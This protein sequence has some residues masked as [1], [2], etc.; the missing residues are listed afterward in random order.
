LPRAHGEPLACGVLRCAPEDFIV[1]EDLGFAPDG[2]GPHVLLRVRKRSSNTEWVAGVLARVAGVR[3]AD[4][5]F[6]GLKDRHALTTQWFTVPAARDATSWRE[7]SHPQ[8][9]ILEAH[10]HRRKL[11]RGALRGNRFQLRIRAVELDAG[12]LEARVAAIR[13]AGVPNYFGPQRFGRDAGNLHAAHRWATAGERADSKSA[14]SF[15]LSAARS[16][17]FNAVLGQRVRGR[18]WSALQPGDVANLEGTGSIFDVPEVTSELHQR[19]AAQDIHPTGPLWGE[20]ELRSAGE[21]RVLEA[22]VAARFDPLGH[23]LAGVGLKQERRSLR[24]AVPTLRAA[25][26]GDVLEVAFELPAGAFATAVVREIVEPRNEER[27][28][29]A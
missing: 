23:A 12:M 2:E 3:A 5:G 29:D 18:T 17:V 11:K 22:A 26:T 24:V 4:V 21:V 8:I 13:G 28:T 16:L 7:F 10:P 14:R 25:L 27:E 20:G 19:M 9:E 1:D 6:A 15:V